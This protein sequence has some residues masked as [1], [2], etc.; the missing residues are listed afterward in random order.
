[1]KKTLIT[2]AIVLLAVAAQAQIKMH[3]S[4]RISFQSLV[5]SPGYGVTIDPGPSWTT[6]FGGAVHFLQGAAFRKNV[7]PLWMD[8][9]RQSQF[10]RSIRLGG[11]AR[12]VHTQIL[13]KR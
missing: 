1:M 5:D 8:E 10:K 6:N 4:G 13:C 9:L 12:L 3:N 11:V 2:I 7:I